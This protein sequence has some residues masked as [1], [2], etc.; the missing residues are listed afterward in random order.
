MSKA[1]LKLSATCATI[2]FKEF[3]FKVFDGTEKLANSMKVAAV[4]SRVV[5]RSVFRAGAIPENDSVEDFHRIKLFLPLR[6][7]LIY[8]SP[9]NCRFGSSQ[10]KSLL[11]IGLIQCPAC[12]TLDQPCK[13]W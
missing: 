11:L 6:D 12:Y 1:L 9:I 4:K 2:H 5:K 10:E 3:I 13:S 7:V 8:Q